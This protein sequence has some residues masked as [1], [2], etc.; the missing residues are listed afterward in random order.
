MNTKDNPQRRSWIVGYYLP[1]L[2]AIFL[3]IQ[4]YWSIAY[5][6]VCALFVAGFFYQRASARGALIA[7]IVGP[8]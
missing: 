1:D 8:A 5:P 4:K 2:K 6:S 7:I 3:Y